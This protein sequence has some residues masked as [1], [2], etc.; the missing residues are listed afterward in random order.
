MLTNEPGQTIIIENPDTNPATAVATIAPPS[1]G[2][3]T[4]PFLQAYLSANEQMS[5]VADVIVGRRPAG[6]TAG[7]AIGQL[8][9]R[10]DNKFIFI[11]R[12]INNGFVKVYEG[13]AAL[14]QDFEGAKSFVPI[15]NEEDP[16]AQEFQEFNPE[17]IEN[18]IFRVEPVKQMTLPDAVQLLTT[19]SQ[20]DQVLPGMGELALTYAEDKRLLNNYKQLLKK[21]EQK[22]KEQQRIAQEQQDAMLAADLAKE[23]INSR[24]Q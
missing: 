19:A 1:I 9:D 16:Q 7:V 15:P 23:Q 20:L 5:G 2:N 18:L 8:Q 10:A 6:V 22:A 11:A 14:I 3:Q 13:L 24:R 12:N 21:M 4:L 17:K